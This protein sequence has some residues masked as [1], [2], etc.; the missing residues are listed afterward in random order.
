[1]IRQAE[2]E[3]HDAGREP[4]HHFLVHGE[5]VVSVDFQTNVSDGDDGATNTPKFQQ[6][7]GLARCDRRGQLAAS[8]PALY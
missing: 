5:V 4:T 6:V 1:V 7:V 8:D 3:V 2:I